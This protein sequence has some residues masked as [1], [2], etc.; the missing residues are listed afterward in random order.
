MA[1]TKLPI[2]HWLDRNQPNA[3]NL[4]RL[5]FALSVIVSHGFALMSPGGIGSQNRVSLG[6]I[7]VNGFFAISGFLITGSWLA[8]PERY[9]RAR[10][11]RI[12]PGFVVA[13][14]F[15]ASVAA[16]SAGPQWLSY[17][18][19][20]NAESLIAGVATLSGGALDQ[21]LAFPLGPWPHTVNGPMWTIAIEF[22]C[23]LGIAILGTLGL[24]SKKP[25]ILSL[26]AFS[27]IF[28]FRNVQT[29]APGWGEQSWPRFATYFGAGVVLN[30]Y[31]TVVPKS[32]LLAVASAIGLALTFET[33]WYFL[34]MPTLGVYL[35]FFSAYSLPGWARSIGAKNDI[36]YGVYLYAFPLQQGYY[37]LHAAGNAPGGALAHIL[38]CTALAVGFGW[39]SWKW[40]EQPCMI[41]VR[42][43]DQKHAA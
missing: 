22:G 15:S 43:L 3:L 11:G 10:V 38:I 19:S 37:Q 21:P 36:S 40:V 4:L 16:A 39:L 29:A 23:Y 41:T 8:S 27:L 30:L 17:L 42:R 9:L 33:R 25:L 26:F 32:W 6:A 5:V 18:R 14:G 24:L 35:L 28:A 20:L 31:R 7:A 1:D 12:V 34:T 2:S 13:L